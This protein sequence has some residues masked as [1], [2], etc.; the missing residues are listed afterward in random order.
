MR[1]PVLAA[2][3]MLLSACEMNAADQVRAKVAENFK[4][5]SE[6]IEVVE[7]EKPTD[8]VTV[9]EA[10]GCGQTTRYACELV[11][12]D[13]AARESDRDRLGGRTTM[14]RVMRCRAQTAPKE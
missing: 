4:C 2:F 12:D 7:V 6:A 10:R 5:R 1:F 13:T 9:Y 3:A 8:Q 14:R 11:D